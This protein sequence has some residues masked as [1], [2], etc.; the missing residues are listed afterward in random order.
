MIADM[1]LWPT[2]SDRIVRWHAGKAA[3]ADLACADFGGDGATVVLLHGLAGCAEEWLET[4]S[5]LAPRYRVLVPDQRGHGRRERRPQ[6]VSRGA[7]VGD[8][9][10]WVERLEAASAVVVGQSLGGQTAFL[11]AAW[12]RDL[13]GLTR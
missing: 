2:P 9:A 1:A 10:M 6:D 7:Y 8:V 12:R 11:V 3:G 5:E 4:V 13:V